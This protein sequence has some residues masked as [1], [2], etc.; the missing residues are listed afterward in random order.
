[1]QDNRHDI[2][3]FYVIPSYRSAG[4]GSQFAIEIFKMSRGPWQARQIEGAHKATLFCHS[5]IQLFTNNN[6]TKS[7]VED[8]Y[9]GKVTKQLFDSP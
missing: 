1:M 2:A 6:F 5:A 4:A 7:A 8:S 9:W 3:E